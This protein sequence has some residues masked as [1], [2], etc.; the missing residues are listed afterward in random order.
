MVDLAV[1]GLQLVLILKDFS[2]LEDFVIRIRL[3]LL[4]WSPLLHCICT[5]YSGLCNTSVLKSYHLCDREAGGFHF[6]QISKLC[7]GLTCYPNHPAADFM[8]RTL[9]SLPVVVIFLGKK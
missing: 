2:N 4:G 3:E 5:L 9:L 7:P 1:L 6:S 8:L